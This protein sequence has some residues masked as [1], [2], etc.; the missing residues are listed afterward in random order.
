MKSPQYKDTYRKLLIPE[1]VRYLVQ[2]HE[3]KGQQ[4]LFVE[5]HKNEL[6]ELLEIARIQSAEASN[7]IEGVVLPSSRLKN[8]VRNKTIPRNQSKWEIAGYRDALTAV[9]ENYDYIPVKPNS[10]LQLHR[11]LYKYSSVSVS[12][13]RYT[14]YAWNWEGDNS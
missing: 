1:I 10:I 11:D 8:L 3:Q 9:H 12:G 2:I 14:S 6:S 13:G 4:N 5:A 7:R